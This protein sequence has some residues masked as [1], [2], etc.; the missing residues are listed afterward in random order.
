MAEVLINF[1]EWVA[2]METNIWFSEVADVLKTMRAELLRVEK[3]NAAL[4]EELLD[5]KAEIVRL[6]PAS[7]EIASLKARVAEL[8]GAARADEERLI[9]AAAKAEVTYF[10]CDTPDHLSD[11]VLALKA[12][13][14]AVVEGQRVVES[15][16]ESLSHKLDVSQARILELEANC[17]NCGLVADVQG[18]AAALLRLVKAMRG[19]GRGDESVVDFTIAYVE[20]LEAAGKKA[21]V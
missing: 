11:A 21:G 1:D 4:K 12:R 17:K 3:E 19:R 16:A 2:G 9:A 8:E 6:D 10:G 15:L 13:Y 20:R 7:L 14:E 5:M 18:D